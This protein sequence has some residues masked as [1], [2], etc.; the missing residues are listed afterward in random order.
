LPGERQSI[1]SRHST[2]S[3]GWHMRQSLSEQF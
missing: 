2:T 3:Q 1:V